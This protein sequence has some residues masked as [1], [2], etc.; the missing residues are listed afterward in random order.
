MNNREEHLD[1][2]HWFG[3]FLLLVLLVV[4]TRACAQTR[5]PAVIDTMACNY[6]SIQKFVET[7]TSTGKPKIYAVYNDEHQ[8]ISDL[9]PVSSTVYNYITVCIKNN[10]T[11]SLAIRLRNGVITGIIRYKVKFVKVLRK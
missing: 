8:G 4:S 5:Q 9:I 11:P 1:P 10:V 7:T 2:G 3:L 6:T